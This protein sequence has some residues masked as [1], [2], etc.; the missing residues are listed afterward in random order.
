[1]VKIGN[2]E[3]KAELLYW[4]TFTWI[5]KISDNELFIG[6]SDYG[7][8]KLKDI[9]AL[10]VPSKGQRFAAGNDMLT[11][12]SISK[13]H[14]I[15]SPV[16]C[17]ILETNS[18]VVNSPDLLNEDAFGNW[19]LRVEVL[20]LSDLDQLIDGE[21]MADEILEEVGMDNRSDGS[22]TF[23]DDDD[24]FDYENEF[25]FDSGDDDDYYDD[26]DDDDGDYYDDDW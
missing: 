23:D 12:E 24:D 9:T 22:R 17:V 18:T 1:M 26:G 13:D 11:I 5:D 3:V 10:S 7:Q 2:F 19:I 8:Q 25:S 21:E 16:S 4:D 20:D 6:L 15:R 14:V